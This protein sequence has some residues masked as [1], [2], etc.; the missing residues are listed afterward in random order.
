[1]SVLLLEG[2]VLN[3]GEALLAGRFVGDVV[4]ILFNEFPKK[5]PLF[6]GFQLVVDLLDDVVGGGVLE[7]ALEDVF[8]LELVVVERDLVFVG[9][10]HALLD[11]VGGETL[12]GELLE[13]VAELLQ[14]GLVLGLRERLQH[15][16]DRV[17]A[18]RVLHDFDA[19][20][21]QH[22]HYPLLLLLQLHQLDHLVYY[23]DPVLVQH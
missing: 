1:M 19:V 3:D 9:S 21:A 2:K 11:D 7:H 10:F 8:L 22:A 23:A 18:V 5:A 16:R 13:E 12:D 4:E 17:V 20:G 15:L 6:L 14:D